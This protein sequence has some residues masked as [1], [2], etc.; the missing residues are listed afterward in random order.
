MINPNDRVMATS[1]THTAV[2]LT[3][4][5]YLASQFMAAIVAAEHS[6]LDR[7]LRNL[8]GDLVRHDGAV[9]RG[10]YADRMAEAAYRLADALIRASTTSPQEN[11]PPG[12]S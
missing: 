8:F 4:R 11:P 5:D 1:A 2:G 12:G 9:S 7:E 10:F 6:Q 3:A